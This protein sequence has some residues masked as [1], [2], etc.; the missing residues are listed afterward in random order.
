MRVGT[1][2]HGK[3]KQHATNTPHRTGFATTMGMWAFL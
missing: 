3:I 1:T 2:R